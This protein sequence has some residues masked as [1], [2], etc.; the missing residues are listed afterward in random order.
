[1]AVAKALRS[2]GVSSDTIFNTTSP[3]RAAKLSVPVE[4]AV[5][6]C[7]HLIKRECVFLQHI[8]QF[9]AGG[10]RRVAKVTQRVAVVSD[11]LHQLFASITWQVSEKLA[12][13]ELHIADTCQTF[14]AMT[15]KKATDQT[16]LPPKD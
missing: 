1:M 7:L 3:P 16:R 2:S 6:V 4:N 11:D 14:H 9:N 8:S 10:F 5:T 15:A 13:N 12:G